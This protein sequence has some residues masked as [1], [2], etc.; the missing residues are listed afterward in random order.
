MRQ[1]CRE[2][3]PHRRV[4]RKPLVSDH[5]M[6]HG[7]CVTHVPWCMSGSLTRGGGENLPGIP[8]ATCNITYL[9][10]GPWWLWRLSVA[11]CARMFYD[12]FVFN[13][14][15]YLLWWCIY[16]QWCLYFY[17][18]D[19]MVMY[20]CIFTYECVFY[21]VLGQRWPNKR[22]EKY[23]VSGNRPMMAV[24]Y[25]A[26]DIIVYSTRSSSAICRINAKPRTDS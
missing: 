4:Q 15:F 12:T 13:F 25:H 1:E 18:K 20:S 9:A 26:Y 19:F 11:I 16:Y 5:R 6:H 2:R 23:Y 14:G 21:Y 8:G 22:S 10:I 7:T 3:F 24:Y 17:Q